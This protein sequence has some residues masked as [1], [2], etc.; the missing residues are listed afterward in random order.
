MLK[1]RYQ[2]KFKG[3][4]IDGNNI[5]KNIEI[6]YFVR[7]L[8]Y[9]LPTKLNLAK[10]IEILKS[11]SLLIDLPFE[12]VQAYSCLANDF[13]NYSFDNLKKDKHFLV[14]FESLR[15]TSS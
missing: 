5:I 8:D 14:S 9:K 12:R 6:N 4:Y 7:K 3:K 13:Y 2:K 15:A 11:K 1:Y 10:L